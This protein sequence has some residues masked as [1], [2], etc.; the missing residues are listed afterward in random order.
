MT[1]S[2]RTVEALCREGWDI[3]R[4]V[5]VLPVTAADEE[6]LEL[7][8]RENRV[9]VTQDLDFSALVALQGFNR[10]SQDQLRHGCTV[11]IEDAVVRVRAVP[12]G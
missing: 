12:I 3:V 7:A 11:T 1:V 2:P 4:V 10:P 5:D 9:V 6:V 8:R